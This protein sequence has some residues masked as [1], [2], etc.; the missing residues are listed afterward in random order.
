MPVLRWSPNQHRRAEAIRDDVMRGLGTDEDYIREDMSA[1]LG[2]AAV[3]VHWRK[4][5]RIDETP[6]MADTPEVRSR[7]GRV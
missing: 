1:M 3:S 4:P 6:R 7:P 2:N 5:L